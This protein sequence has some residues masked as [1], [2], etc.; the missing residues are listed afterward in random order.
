MDEPSFSNII[1]PN[2]DLRI[3]FPPRRL[4]QQCG[5]PK[6][7]PKCLPSEK[8]QYVT[9]QLDFIDTG[10]YMTSQNCCLLMKWS[11]Q[12]DQKSLNIWEEFNFFL[13]EEITMTSVFDSYWRLST[14]EQTTSIYSSSEIDFFPDSVS[15][16]TQLLWNLL[17]NFF[18]KVRDIRFSWIFSLLH[19]NY[20]QLKHTFKVLSKGWTQ[21]IFKK[22][23]NI[24]LITV[25]RLSVQTK[26]YNIDFFP[27]PFCYISIIFAKSVLLYDKKT[28]YYC[29]NGSR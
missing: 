27:N 2:T 20:T 18:K 10:M 26:T 7:S 19:D 29:A 14:T 1:N 5:Y 16:V 24:S 13:V 21:T 8:F 15:L 28:K 17:S 11:C 6:Y 22:T 9:L 25:S 23:W 4:V 12:L 3:A